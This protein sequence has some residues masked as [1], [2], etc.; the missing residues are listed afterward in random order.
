MGADVKGRVR[1]C[2]L[3][4]RRR[5][6]A[7]DVVVGFGWGVV[8]SLERGAAGKR[9]AEAWLKHGTVAETRHSGAE[10]AEG[11]LYHQALQ[12]AERNGFE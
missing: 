12:H 11:A 6:V 7:I 10:M 2:R 8:P 3:H 4:I 9:S 1:A 5:L